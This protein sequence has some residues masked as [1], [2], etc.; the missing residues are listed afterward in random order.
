MSSIKQWWNA[1]EGDEKL[2]YGAAVVVP[3]LI[4]LYMYFVLEIKT[5]NDLIKAIAQIPIWIISKII[6]F[7]RELIQSI[8]AGVKES[9][10]LK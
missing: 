5:F 6:Y 2:I 4:F 10:K 9:L 3:I 8:I 7:F 1:L